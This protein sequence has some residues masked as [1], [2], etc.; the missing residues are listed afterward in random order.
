MQVASIETSLIAENRIQ[1]FRIVDCE[2]QVLIGGNF[3]VIGDAN[4]NS[5]SCICHIHGFDQAATASLS[6][7]TMRGKS[8]NTFLAFAFPPRMFNNG[9]R[10]K[11]SSSIERFF[12]R[13]SRTSESH[14]SFSGVSLGV[15]RNLST[16]LLT[17]SSSV[18]N[19]DCTAE[20]CLTMEIT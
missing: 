18:S 3:G 14:C 5:V 12:T 9:V 19:G 15:V 10:S 16:A 1:T 4:D 20:A 13:C 8:L 7:A 17:R 11:S 6:S 2:S